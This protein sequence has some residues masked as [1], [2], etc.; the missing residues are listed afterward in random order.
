MEISYNVKTVFS[1]NFAL[2][3]YTENT[4]ILLGN[5]DQNNKIV[6]RKLLC[7]GALESA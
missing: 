4:I 3:N 7:F 1:Y 5:E 2:S 6:A